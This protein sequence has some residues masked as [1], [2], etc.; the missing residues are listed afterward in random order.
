METK[1]KQETPKAAESSKFVK[2]VLA[3]TILAL[4]LIAVLVIGYLVCRI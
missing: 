4:E 1:A 3:W 2:P